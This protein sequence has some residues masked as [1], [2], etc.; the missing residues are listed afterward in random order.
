MPRRPYRWWAA[1][2]VAA[3]CLAALAFALHRDE[4]FARTQLDVAALPEPDGPLGA[5]HRAV[6][7]S[8]EADDGDGA[9]EYTIVAGASAGTGEAVL[10]FTTE[11]GLCGIAH[12]AGPAVGADTH[13][14]VTVPPPGGARVPS[15]ERGH[16]TH[17]VPGGPWSRAW[18]GGGLET[19][20][21]LRYGV[22]CAREAMVGEWCPRYDG[23]PVTAVGT[24]S[25]QER[26]DG[27]WL[28]AVAEE[29]LLAEITEA[30]RR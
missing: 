7:E 1:G 15:A 29:P 10:L 23:V 24:G 21:R 14:A 3:V 2:V 22:S 19:P 16:P 11:A 4:P 9:G 5:F 26:P 18:T 13:G 28:L 30:L 8:G 17:G 12:T 20:G 6:R 27:C 25:A